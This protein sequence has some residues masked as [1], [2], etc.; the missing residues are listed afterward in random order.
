MVSND[1]LLDTD[2]LEF[3]EQRCGFNRKVMLNCSKN[4]FKDNI[5]RTKWQQR[6]Q[7]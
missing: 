4:R 6:S 3:G 1:A 2:E 5:W 7:K